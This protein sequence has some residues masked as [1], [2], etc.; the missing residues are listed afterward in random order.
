MAKALAR[1]I[2]NNGG[3]L[4]LTNSELTGFARGGN[5]ADGGRGGVGGLAGGLNHAGAAGG[6]GGNAG[7][8]GWAVGGSI[9]NS[10]N[11]TVVIQNGS[12][13]NVTGTATGGVGGNGSTGGQGGTGGDG[14]GN[15]GAGASGGLAGAGG[16]AIGGGIYNDTGSINITVGSL[17][18]NSFGG[19]GGNGGNGGSGGNATTLVGTTGAGGPGG[20]G[21]NGG[22]AGISAGGAL[23]NNAGAVTIKAAT[24]SGGAGHATLITSGTGGQAG[25][26][27]TGDT[28]D[29]T[30]LGGAAGH[31]GSGGV[32]A[33]AAGGAIY[34]AGG[35]ILV[36]S[37]TIARSLAEGGDG[38]QAGL[39]GFGGNG[40]LHG[41]AAQTSPNGGTGGDAHGGAIVVFGGTLTLSGDTF[42]GDQALGGSG[43]AGGVGGASGAAGAQA[44]IGVV[45]GLGGD[46]GSGFGGV[47]DLLGGTLNI[48][49]GTFAEDVGIGFNSTAGG[50]G[51]Q[52][53]AG[54]GY[55]TNEV[56][57]NGGAGGIGG[58]GMGGALHTSGGT[59]NLT[60]ATLSTNEAIAGIGG[61]GG[62]GGT[63]SA[64]NGAT[65]GTGQASGGGIAVDAG[66]VKV[67]NSIVAGNTADTNS[68]DV[69]GLFTSL[70]GNLIGNAS[71]SSGF[72]GT[73]QVGSTGSPIDPM[74]GP[75]QAN[76]GPTLTMALLAGSSAINGDSECPGHRS[77]RRTANHPARHWRL[78]SAVLQP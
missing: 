24:I 71:G 37:S 62:I 40:N 74:L 30:S 28:S 9:Y 50:S 66:S 34:S 16:S 47:V 35:T 7:S 76:G 63:A 51:G 32:G 19:S 69:V 3:S 36:D 75:L 68:P 65:G 64:S 10:G 29:L 52:G 58:N 26:G 44:G 13:T 15:G 67:L 25:S 14:S 70:G 18:G 4:T 77:T 2:Y 23:Y 78:R 53:G 41:G 49:N 11:G 39:G 1:A 54:G 6:A 27:G 12:A 72:G 20:D 55:L 73:D 48:V 17:L 56:P 42:Y 59:L 57:A 31:A 5:G 43:G 61:G 45:G 21:Q 38:G 8:G 46:G 33:Q 22:S 60:N